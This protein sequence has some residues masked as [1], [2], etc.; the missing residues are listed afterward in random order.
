MYGWGGTDPNKWKGSKKY[1]FGSARA[2]YDA[3]AVSAGATGPRSYSF[4]RTPN[5]SLVDPR[6]KEISSDSTD[7]I[8]VG[9]DVTGS[10]ALWPGEM[11]DREPLFCQTLAKYRPNAEFCFCA[12]GDANSDQY[13]LQVTGFTKD[14]KELEANIKALG[15]EGGGGGQIMES[16]ELFAQFM[17]TK[18]K[19]PNATSPFLLMYGDE[20]FYDQVNPKQVKHWI[21]DKLESP[22]ES[23]AVFQELMQKFNVYFLQ[24]HYGNDEHDVTKEVK[25]RWADAIGLQRIIDLPYEIKM[26]GGGTMP[27]YQRAIDLGMGL[28]AKHWGEYMDFGKSLDARHDDPA[29]KS[30]VHKSLRHIDGNPTAKSVT[31]TPKKSRMTR[32]LI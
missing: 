22:L 9:I 24:K 12:I 4:S 27:G 14:I 31:S 10:M 1:D 13:P 7:P 3:A 25:E 5:M 30:A 21:G 26:E 19:T 2:R 17:N 15:C 11:F 20:K 16:Y 28:I 32:P 29:V 18:C 8:I 23:K 6:G